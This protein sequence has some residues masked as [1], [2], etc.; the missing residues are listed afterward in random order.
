MIP[1]PDVPAVAGEPGVL[2]GGAEVTVTFR[3]SVVEPVLVLGRGRFKIAGARSDFCDRLIC[4]GSVELTACGL[5]DVM[6]VGGVAL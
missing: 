4:P 2:T 5:V 3:F 1:E 6:I